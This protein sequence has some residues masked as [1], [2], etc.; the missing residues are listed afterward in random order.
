MRMMSVPFAKHLQAGDRQPESGL[1]I[2]ESLV[3][4]IMVAI[5]GAM[6]T[7]P[8]VIA[9]ATRLQNQRAQQAYQI[10]Q[11]ELDRVRG[12]VNNG[13]HEPAA[14]PA[15]VGNAPLANQGPPTGAI[16]QIQSIDPDCNTYNGAPLPA[17]RAL[18]IDIT[19]NCEPDFVMQ[20]FRNNGVVSDREQGGLDRPI[21]FAMA[22]RV[23]AVLDNPIPWGG[24]ETEEAG[25]RFTSGDGNQS[26]RPLAVITTQVNW[27]DTRDSLC[28]FHSAAGG[29]DG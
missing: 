7:P 12:L 15:A 24:M 11:G 22:V 16:N 13:R 20:V 17:N 3:A 8:I 27:S 14:L 29:C 6:I 1:T 2:I 28:E 19:G 5:V 9:V 21:S 25:L 23:Y 10:A 4:I 26:T 18:P